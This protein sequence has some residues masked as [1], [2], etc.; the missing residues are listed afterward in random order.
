MAP[1]PPAAT[2]ADEADGGPDRVL[3]DDVDAARIPVSDI[4]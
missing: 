1:A 4:Y 3:I 2:A